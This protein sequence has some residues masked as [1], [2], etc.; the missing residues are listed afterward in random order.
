MR[1]ITFE[2]GGQSWTDH[3][4]HG[5]N[6]GGPVA[7]L[8]KQDPLMSFPPLMS[9]NLKPLVL[10]LLFLTLFGKIGHTG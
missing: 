4:E 10:D 2:T 9:P 8:Q 1:L 6:P 5:R 7:I 3:W